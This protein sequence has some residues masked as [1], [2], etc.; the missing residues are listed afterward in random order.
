MTRL[1]PYLSTVEAAEFLHL[2]PKTLEGYRCRGGGP[3][4]RKHGRKVVYRLDELEA[5]SAAGNRTSTSD[6]GPGQ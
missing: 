3:A 1:S 2:S 5:W 6:P 4:Y